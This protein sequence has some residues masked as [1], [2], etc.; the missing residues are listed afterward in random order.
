MTTISDSNIWTDNT[1]FISD[2]GD[3]SMDAFIFA[4]NI[5]L[6]KDDCVRRM[7]NTIK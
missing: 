1:I 3:K 7:L 4:I 2:L 6:R 5:E